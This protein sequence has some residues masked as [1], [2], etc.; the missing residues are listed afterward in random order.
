M[1]FPGAGRA[2]LQATGSAAAA[3]SSPP[4]LMMP[5]S[6]A[7]LCFFTPIGDHWRTRQ[8]RDE[9]LIYPPANERPIV[10]CLRC[11]ASAESQRRRLAPPPPGSSEGGAALW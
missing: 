1:N 6:V 9:T 2:T 4:A 5:C 11:L 8:P 10:R 3:R 7:G